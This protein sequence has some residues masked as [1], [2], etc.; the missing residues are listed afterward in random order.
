MAEQTAESMENH[1]Q[2]RARRSTVRSY[3]LVSEYDKAEKRDEERLEKQ[4]HLN[5]VMA[6]AIP[7]EQ[8][9]AA[10][11][12][13]QPSRRFRYAQTSWDCCLYDNFHEG[14][15][16]SEQGRDLLEWL[17]TFAALFKDDDHRSA[18]PTALGSIPG[19]QEISDYMPAYGMLPLIDK[20]WRGA[21]LAAYVSAPASQKASALAKLRSAAS[22]RALGD[23]EYKFISLSPDTLELAIMSTD[24]KTY[25]GA[26]IISSTLSVDAIKQRLQQHGLESHEAVLNDMGDFF[27]D[28]VA[29]GKA[30]MR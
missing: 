28:L 26:V 19:G 23:Y 22:S 12:E 10:E 11:V 13:V 18:D 15:F 7:A 20:T 5:P 2:K 27:E 21:E 25:G 1:P 6:P 16:V 8:A 3:Y 30:V 29:S 4:K 9:V 24:D 14:E 17:Y